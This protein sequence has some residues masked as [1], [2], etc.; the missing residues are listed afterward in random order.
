MPVVGREA[1][2]CRAGW[3]PEVLRGIASFPAE[4]HVIELIHAGVG[5]RCRRNAWRRVDLER[6]DLVA[7]EWR[8]VYR[9]RQLAADAR[10]A[11]GS[12]DFRMNGVALLELEVVDG[13]GEC[14]DEGINWAPCLEVSVIGT[15]GTSLRWRST[16]DLARASS[17]A[18]LT[19]ANSASAAAHG[20]AV[21]AQ[22]RLLT[23]AASARPSPTGT[24]S[25]SVPAARRPST[26]AV[27]LC[28]RIARH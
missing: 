26:T 2:V 28:A 27:R 11:W 3:R 9:E 16:G 4:C 8:R 5:E 13:C 20:A 7:A 1:G 6:E 14:P 23:S 10:V 17:A 12:G 18:R 24:D 19:P 15:K 25:R 21:T 22:R